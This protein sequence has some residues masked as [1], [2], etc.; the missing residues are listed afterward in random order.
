MCSDKS[1]K[2]FERIYDDKNFKQI[3]IQQCINDLLICLD[4]DG[5][6]F[7]AHS[8]ARNVELVQLITPTP[9]KAVSCGRTH[10][11]VIDYDGIV[12]L[13]GSNNDLGQLGSNEDISH[14][15]GL[16]FLWS[17]MLLDS[18]RDIYISGSNGSG[19]LGVGSQD[20]FI[21]GF[22]YYKH[23]GVTC[24][25]EQHENYERNKFKTTKRAR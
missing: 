1:N 10:F 18:D 3:C 19:E 6:L 12:T 25:A 14:Y 15:P 24:L 8:F 5:N 16:N 9:Y 20:P 4:T 17:T 7:I 23:E 13:F 11:G 2:K 21:K 22:I